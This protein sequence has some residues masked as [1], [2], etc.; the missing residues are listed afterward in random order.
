MNNIFI[1][2]KFLEI[3]ATYN[4]KELSHVPGFHNDFNIFIR[5]ELRGS[6]HHFVSLEGHVSLSCGLDS[7]TLEL[8]SSVNFHPMYELP[9][10]CTLRRERCKTV[11][12]IGIGIVEMALIPEKFSETMYCDGYL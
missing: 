3:I 7:G 10:R 2:L 4:F 12:I 1:T 5:N 8:G 9:K 11:L 6:L